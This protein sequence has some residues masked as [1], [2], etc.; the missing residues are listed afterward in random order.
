[1]TH[2]RLVDF[3]W[4]SL[5]SLNRHATALAAD[6]GTAKVECIEKTL[7]KIAKWVQVDARRELWTKEHGAHLLEGVDWVVG[8]SL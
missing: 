4:V 5:S 3:D 7:R 8:E 6:V 1:M 2:I